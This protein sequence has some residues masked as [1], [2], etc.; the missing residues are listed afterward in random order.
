MTAH[1][2][3]NTERGADALVKTCPPQTPKTQLPPQQQ[4]AQTSPFHH[5]TQ[6]KQKPAT[7]PSHNHHHPSSTPNHHPL[8]RSASS[9][10]RE[11]KLPIH[12]SANP[13]PA[14]QPAESLSPHGVVLVLGTVRRQ[15]DEI[16]G[17]QAYMPHPNDHSCVCGHSS[18]PPRSRR[19]SLRLGLETRLLSQII[20]KSGMRDVIDGHTERLHCLIMAAESL[21]LNTTKDY[22]IL[23]S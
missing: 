22:G 21:L 9:D 17:L 7:S 6:S 19:P 23:E 4:T 12:S 18:H 3:Q 1:N 13:L 14:H 8:T 15:T 5:L 16:P 11:G 2:I 20:M 10:S